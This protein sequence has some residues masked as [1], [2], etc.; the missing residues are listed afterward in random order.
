MSTRYFVTWRQYSKA[1]PE[2]QRAFWDT[3]IDLWSENADNQITV[4]TRFDRS[5]AL[6]PWL[7]EYTVINGDAKRI[8]HAGQMAQA[9]SAATGGRLIR[10][11]DD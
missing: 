4:D 11:T 9:A 5:E 8:R 1:T 6:E 3:M 2:E 10:N 7:D